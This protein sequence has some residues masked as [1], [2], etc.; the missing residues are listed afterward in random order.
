MT[1]ES[2]VPR[3]GFGQRI[4]EYFTFNETR[5]AQAKLGETRRAKVSRAIELGRQ[6]AEAAE[7]LW[8]NG[9]AAEG[10]Q[11]SK[12]AFEATTGAV[13]S[14]R[15]D[16]EL[17]EGETRPST[18]EAVVAFMKQ[19]GARE[20]GIRTVERAFDL[21]EKGNLPELDV[22]VGSVHA[23]SHQQFLNGRHQIDR[24]FGAVA[25]PARDLRVS[26]VSRIATV[27]LG[28]ALL[29]GGLVVALRRPSI[30]VAEA[31]STWQ[32]SPQFQPANAIDDNPGTW[33]ILPDGQAGWIERRLGSARHIDR[34]RV[35]NSANPPWNDRQTNEY[36]I[37][38]YSGSNLLQAIDGSFAESNSPQPVT[39]EASHDNVDRVRFVVRSHHRSSGG[40]SELTVE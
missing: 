28:G 10:L 13:T 15:D 20:A 26:S 23:E 9:H 19:N 27:G 25:S 12:L 40:L 17:P 7:T 22:E 36:R 24:L 1:T 35:L 32:D 11:L 3:L 30:D 18:R 14:L 4:V 6:R 38:I 39:H 16:E 21:A 8:S 33:W 29:V 37:E 31:S 34:V 2:I 5:R